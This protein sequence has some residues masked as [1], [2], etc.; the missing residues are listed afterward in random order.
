VFLVDG[1][2]MLTVV[3]DGATDAGADAK[4][5]IISSGAAFVVALY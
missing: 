1:A 2:C 4:P 5:T 3:A